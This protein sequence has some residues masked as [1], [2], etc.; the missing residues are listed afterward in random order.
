[1]EIT[2]INQAYSNNMKPTN[3]FIIAI[4]IGLAGCGKKEES[5]NPN[6]DQ[7]NSKMLENIASAQGWQIEN[8]EAR[9]RAFNALESKQQP[10]DADWQQLVKAADSEKNGF[11]LSLAMEFSRHMTSKY[12]AAVLKWCERN[13]EQTADASAA[14]IGYDCYLRSGGSNKDL[15]AGRLK[16]RGQFYIDKIAEADQ[17]AATRKN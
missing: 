17:R 11:D 10:T 5:A 8:V 9:E 2:A 3:I 1:V 15:W 16:A 7:S 6:F 4:L 12:S 14:V 13:M